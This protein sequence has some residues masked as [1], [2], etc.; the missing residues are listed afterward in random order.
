MALIHTF[1]LAIFRS[2][3]RILNTAFGWATILLF[4]RVP[5]QRQ[6]Y[7]SVMAFGSVLWIVSAL[8]VAFPS[9]GTFLLAFVTLPD[10][11]KDHVRVGM[12]AAAAV[13]PAIVGGVTIL[14]VDPGDRPRG[15]WARVRAILS[16]YP[17]TFALALTLLF[18]TAIAPVVK[19]RQ[20][21]KRWSDVHIPVV[22]KPQD[23]ER[24]VLDVKK[25]LEAGGI[26]PD[27]RVASWTL[28]APIALFAALARGNA[29]SL[30][31]ANLRTLTAPGLEVYLY[32]ADLAIFGT[33]HD[34]G[35]AHA[36]ITERLAFSTA[37]LTRAKETQELE[38]ELRAL[39]KDSQGN[40]RG[41]AVQRNLDR[42]RA[43]DERIR[44][45]DLAYDDWEA[46]FRE[47]L[48][49]ERSLLAAAAHA[50]DG[51]DATERFLDA[52]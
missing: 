46:L 8:G 17:Y 24:I 21:A 12:L 39:W 23:Y 33:E 44:G 14:L 47:R 38:D 40:A 10:W 13:I 22:V 36:V 48:L 20:V 45:L 29:T 37:Y 43:L 30:V 41:P 1:L 2:M 19:L 7:L 42:F 31:A 15:A 28:R 50:T 25:A 11:A 49:L 51:H 9:V 26:R 5:Q 34:A 16:G 6:V 4:G 35:H 52:A 32:P 18:L 27:V 3:G